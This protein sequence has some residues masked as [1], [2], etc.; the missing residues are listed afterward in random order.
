MQIHGPPQLCSE[1]WKMHARVAL[2]GNPLQCLDSPLFAIDPGMLC[3]ALESCWF[4]VCCNREQ[5]RG[6]AKY[7]HICI[8]TSNRVPPITHLDAWWPRSRIARLNMEWMHIWTQQDRDSIMVDPEC[9]WSGFETR[10]VT[11][12]TKRPSFAVF[13]LTPIPNTMQ[14]A[15]HAWMQS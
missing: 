12:N 4:L 6:M 5:E 14:Y 1:W 8:H 7:F 10:S 2:R 13:G 15:W 11:Q 3:K 9:R